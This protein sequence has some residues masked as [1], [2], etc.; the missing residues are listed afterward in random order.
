M[1]G[2]IVGERGNFDL[3]FI[4]VDF[5]FVFFITFFCYCFFGRFFVS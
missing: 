5:E 1:I 2:W 3:D 4:V